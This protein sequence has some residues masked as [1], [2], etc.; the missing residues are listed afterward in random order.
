M[1]DVNDDGDG[2]SDD[3]EEVFSGSAS[4]SGSGEDLKTVI[5]EG[6]TTTTRPTDNTEQTTVTYNVNILGINDPGR[7]NAG[8]YLSSSILLLTA[9]FLVQEI[10]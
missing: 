3:Q 9:T 4:G 6:T 2:E 8:T 7:G 10:L 1:G 5:I